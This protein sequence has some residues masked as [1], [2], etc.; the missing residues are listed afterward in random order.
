M[1][2]IIITIKD[3]NI[4]MSIDEFKKHIDDAYHQG[5]RDASSITSTTNDNQWWKHLAYNDL[6]IAGTISRG[7]TVET[8]T[9]L[10]S[11]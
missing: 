6:S 8:D 10:A 2:P 7:T 3:N 9:A 1:K 11:K 5:Y 4:V